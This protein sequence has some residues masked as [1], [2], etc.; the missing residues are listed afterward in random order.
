MTE[1][2]KC[3]VCGNPLPEG[4][5]SWHACCSYSCGGDYLKDPDKWYIPPKQ[6]NIHAEEDEEVF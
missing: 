4:Q 3:A 5:A 1:R 6:S 2:K